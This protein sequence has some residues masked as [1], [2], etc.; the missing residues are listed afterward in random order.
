MLDI[1]RKGMIPPKT[2]IENIQ[3]SPEKRLSW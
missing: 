2:S 1:L 3:N